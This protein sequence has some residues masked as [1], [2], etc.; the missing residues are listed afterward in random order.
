MLMVV[1]FTDGPSFQISVADLVE[2]FALFFFGS[3]IIK[4]SK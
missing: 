1:D 2:I 3:L 4:I